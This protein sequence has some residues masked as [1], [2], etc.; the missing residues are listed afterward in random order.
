MQ[1]FEKTEMK[2]SKFNKGVSEDSLD[3]NDSEDPRTTEY[4]EESE[5]MEKSEEEIGD[6]DE[7]E[8]TENEEAITQVRNNIPSA[9]SGTLEVVRQVLV[10]QYLVVVS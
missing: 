5:R 8:G 6:E 2:N 3:S 1:L 7:Y 4:T 10:Y 9:A